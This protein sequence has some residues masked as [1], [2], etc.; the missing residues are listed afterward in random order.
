MPLQMRV[1]CRAAFAH[2]ANRG[3]RLAVSKQPGVEEFNSDV[4]TQPDQ[5][6]N[7][8]LDHLTP[9][10]FGE[11]AG[12]TITEGTEFLVTIERVEE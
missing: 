11:L 8:A 4:F 1:N 3:V 9:E 12:E 10:A 6:V 7:I 2:E 5:T